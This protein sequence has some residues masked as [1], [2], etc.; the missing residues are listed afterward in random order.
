MN[1]P[2]E[3]A[4]EN[5]VCICCGATSWFE[6]DGTWEGE[7][8][9]GIGWFYHDGCAECKACGNYQTLTPPFGVTEGGKAFEL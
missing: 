1:D 2:I 6:L 8:E 3:K 9:N 5:A 7:D 4:M